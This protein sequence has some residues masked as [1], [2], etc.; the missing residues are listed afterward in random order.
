MGSF[1]QKEI[2]RKKSTEKRVS[3]D[4]APISKDRAPEG[5][6]TAAAPVVS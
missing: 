6:P 1:F 4:G 3:K 2:S 5:A